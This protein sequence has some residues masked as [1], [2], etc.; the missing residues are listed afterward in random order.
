[1]C[2]SAIVLILCPPEETMQ[3]LHDLVQAGSVR[4]IGTSSCAALQFHVT[5]SKLFPQVNGDLF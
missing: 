3:A 1:M 5:Q 4:Y 2:F